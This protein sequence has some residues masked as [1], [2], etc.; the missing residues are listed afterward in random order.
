MQAQSNAIQA[1]TSIASNWSNDLKVE[2]PETGVSL[3]EINRYLRGWLGH[4]THI[5]GEVVRL[6]GGNL[7]I[8][9]RA[10]SQAGQSFSGS[11]A[12]FHAVLAKTA[13]AIYAET[14]PFRYTSIL[15]IQGRIPEQESLIRTLS[16]TGPASDRAWAYAGLS[17]ILLGRN[18][19]AEA[20]RASRAAMALSPEFAFGWY[21]M[22]VVLQRAGNLQDA[23]DAARKSLSLQPGSSDLTPIAMVQGLAAANVVVADD[24]GDFDQ[25][26]AQFAATWPMLDFTAEPATQTHDAETATGGGVLTPI[27]YQST[28]AI[29]RIGQHDLGAARRVLAQEPSF[30]AALKV[31]P[32]AARRGQIYLDRAAEPY[33]NA[34][35]ALAIETGSWARVRQMVPVMEA[36][37]Q[38]RAAA[39]LGSS[40][41]LQAVLRPDLALAEAE[42]GDFAAAHARIDRTDPDCDLCLRTRAKIDALQRNPGGADFWFARAESRAPSIP[43]ADQDWGRALLARGDAAGAIEKFKASSAKGPHFADPLEGW[44]EALM[45]R[46]QAHL[47]VAKFA[48]A[49]KYAP[50]WGRLH[51]KWGEALYYM[52]RKDEARAQFARAAALDLT[53]AEKAELTGMTHV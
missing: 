1:P 47:A 46:N 36:D 40:F 30:I 4:E 41:N 31:D 44:G 8:T 53:P 51:L 42:M 14:Q 17:S 32:V 10:N 26:I 11:E 13:E 22:A 3:G 29:A 38:R 21:R 20:L 28:L 48:E 15:A 2:I 9:A 7:E 35:L 19:T 49:N 23:L 50:N 18:Q 27:G 6:E 12:D 34:E 24:L 5:S 45:T 37:A 43:F 52:G 25:Q 16:R 33:R 39:H